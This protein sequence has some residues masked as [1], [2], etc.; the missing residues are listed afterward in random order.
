MGTYSNYS[1]K[2]LVIDI[3]VINI[4]YRETY[5]A[6]QYLLFQDFNLQKKNMMATFYFFFLLMLTDLHSHT[7]HSRGE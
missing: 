1:E 6:T 4:L 7:Q 3:W 2:C 5:T